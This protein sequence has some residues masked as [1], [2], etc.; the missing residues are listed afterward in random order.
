MPMTKLSA[1]KYNRQFL[2][3]IIMYISENFLYK[4]YIPSPALH[5]EWP[6]ELIYQVDKDYRTSIF[7][8]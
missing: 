6:V 2:L 3:F 8:D 1:T 4:F 5:D 7:I